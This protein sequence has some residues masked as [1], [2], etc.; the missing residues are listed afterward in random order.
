[1]WTCDRCGVNVYGDVCPLCGPV[2]SA[3]DET[4]ERAA[5]A[6]NIDDQNNPHHYRE[7]T[8]P[9]R[10][11]LLTLGTLCI[12]GLGCCGGL[13]GAGTALPRRGRSGP[14]SWISS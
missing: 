3:T 5:A 8:A 2:K 7:K 6:L 10:T 14:T 13:Y 4:E 9:L 1:M 12:A 11:C